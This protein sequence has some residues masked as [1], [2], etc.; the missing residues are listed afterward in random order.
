MPVTCTPESLVNSAECLVCL[1]EKQQLAVQT[2]LLAGIA[3]ISASPE[4]LLAAA[5]PFTELSLKELLVI[6]AYLLC[7]INGG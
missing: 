5:T 7:K 2:Y 3:G 1:S 6:Q 4:T